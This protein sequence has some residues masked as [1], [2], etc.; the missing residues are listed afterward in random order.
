M[1]R[2]GRWAFRRSSSTALTPNACLGWATITHP[3]HPLRGQRFEVLK[4][5][6]AGGME[7][8]ML[9]HAER[10]SYAIARD[11]TDWSLSEPIPPPDGR[12]SKLA[13]ETL[14]ELTELVTELAVR[15]GHTLDEA[16]R[17]NHAQTS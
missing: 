8:V 7:I 15:E 5:R 3:F 6:R 14:A 4:T 1:E 17:V 11:W 16:S 12:L 9:R 2:K 10:G 13:L